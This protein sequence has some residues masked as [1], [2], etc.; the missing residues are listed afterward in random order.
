MQRLVG[1]LAE[2]GRTRE[3]ALGYRRGRGREP[4]AA[5]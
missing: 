4:A 1:A 2:V 3:N 5:G